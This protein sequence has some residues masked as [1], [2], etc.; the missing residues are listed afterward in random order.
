MRHP[1]HFLPVDED[2]SRRR[3]LVANEQPYQRRLACTARSYEKAEV[4]LM[5]RQINVAQ[6]LR[7]VRVD[8]ADAVKR[9]YRAQR[10]LRG[11]RRSLGDRH[12]H[13]AAP[14]GDFFIG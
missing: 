8:L 7:S 4:A 6:G 10:V 13:Q 2:P 5:D 11:G 3:R 14:W 9:D 1:A 12:A